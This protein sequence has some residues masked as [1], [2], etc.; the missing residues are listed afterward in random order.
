LYADGAIQAACLSFPLHSYK[1][2]EVS[3]MLCYPFLFS[4]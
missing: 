3:A 4:N 1:K 2:G